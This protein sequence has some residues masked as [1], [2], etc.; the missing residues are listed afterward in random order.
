MRS[1]KL[2]SPADRRLPSCI[3]RPERNKCDAVRKEEESPDTNALCCQRRGGEI[4]MIQGW[5]LGQESASI[6]L[7]ILQI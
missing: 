2:F 5:N 4:Q 1:A 7:P 3:R 6:S